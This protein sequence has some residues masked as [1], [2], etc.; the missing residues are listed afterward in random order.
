MHVRRPDRRARPTGT[1]CSPT[2][3]TPTPTACSARI[4][5]LDAPRGEPLHADPRLGRATPSRGPRACAFAPRC[6]NAIDGVHRASRR[7]PL[8]ARRRPRAA[9]LPQPAW[10]RRRCRRPRPR[11]A[12][13]TSDARRRCVDVAGL[14][15]HFPI[16]RGR[17]VRPDGRPRLR[18]R[19][20]R[21]RDPRAARPTAWSVSP[22]AASRRSAGRSCGWCEPT[23]GTVDLRR[24]R[25]RRR[26]S[27]E[28][29]R[30]MRRR[31][32]DGLPGPAGQP[33]PAADRSSRCSTEPLQAHGLGTDDRR[34]TTAVARAARRRSGLPA[35]RAA[36]STRT[37]SP[38]ASAS[39]SA[40]PGRCARTRT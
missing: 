22:A 10:V 18:R 1:S 15:V 32:A 19:R 4:P 33:R 5:R 30:R 28:A 9:A 37:S 11:V 14:K 34:P 16:K 40:S 23:E 21:P 24:H 7:R 6:R 39:A 20:R 25:H 8:R 31:H 2:R 13:A 26:S 35:A 36:R 17:A 29:L 27:G 38:A 3:G 12:A